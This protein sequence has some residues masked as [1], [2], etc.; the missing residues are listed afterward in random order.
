MKSERKTNPKRLLIIVNKLRPLEG[1]G[2]EGWGTWVID[3]KRARDVMSTGCY[4]RLM[5]H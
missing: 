2:V 1:K 4:I 5:S 3:I